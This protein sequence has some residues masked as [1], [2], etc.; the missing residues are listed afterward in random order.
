MSK[1]AA[2]FVRHTT[3]LPKTW[4]FTSGELESKYKA[5]RVAKGL[6]VPFEIKTV[7]LGPV[8]R[9]LP[10][11]LLR[12][13]AGTNLFKKISG[14]AY[15]NENQGNNFQWP[16]YVIGSAQDAMPFCLDV[17]KRSKNR[18]LSSFIGHPGVNFKLFD[19][20]AMTSIDRMRLKSIGPNLPNNDHIVYTEVS[21]DDITS[22]SINMLPVPIISRKEGEI[23]NEKYYS[24]DNNTNSTTVAKQDG[25]GQRKVADYL[26]ATNFD[27]KLCIHINPQAPSKVRAAILDTT[28]SIQK[29]RGPES[30]AV[31]DGKLEDANSNPYI[32]YLLQANC[33][34]TTPDSLDTTSSALEL[35]KKVYIAS[36]EKTTGHLRSLHQKLNKKGYLRR[37]YIEGTGYSH[38]LV[39]SSDDAHYDPLSALGDRIPLRTMPPSEAHSAIAK[40][41]IDKWNEKQTL[42]Q[43]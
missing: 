29:E 35:G 26:L 36:Q 7:K 42:L 41:I 4:I 38:M 2:A 11:I 31:W 40:R 9:A 39:T 33:I 15:Q 25:Q 10:P 13:L 8:V 19:V 28:E 3:L 14:S 22:A 37:L 32:K 43:V 24:N 12:F 21:N 30:V 23:L 20:V 5:I 17:I 1:K 27:Y 16:Q 18:T 34:V 6:G